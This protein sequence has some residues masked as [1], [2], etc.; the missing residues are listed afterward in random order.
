MAIV[1]GEI[2]FPSRDVTARDPSGIA[3]GGA[4]QCA[5]P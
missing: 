1:G 2:R 4:E 5:G 3:T